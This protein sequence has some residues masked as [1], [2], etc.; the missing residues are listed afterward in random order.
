MKNILIAALMAPL[1]LCAGCED[2]N[3]G[4]GSG[5]TFPGQIP[6][7]EKIPVVAW[8]G[9][10]SSF[11][12][13]E[14]FK[15]AEAMG[16]TLNYSRM[17]NTT[18]AMKMLDYAAQTNIKLIVE[19]DELYKD[20]ER[21]AAVRRLMNHKALA[22]Y[23]ID[24]EPEPSKFEGIATRIK[25][26]SAIDP[27]H[28]C[29][30]N[31]FPT[32][33]NETY[34]TAWGKP[35]G[36]GYADYAQE[37]IST[38]K[39]QFFSFDEYPIHENGTGQ[40]LMKGTWFPTLEIARDEADKNN[41]ELWAFLLT[42]P[43]TAYPQPTHDHLRMQAYSNLAYGAQVLQCFT[44][45][46]PTVDNSV[47]NWNYRNGPIEED[48]TRSATYNVV[49]NLLEEVQTLAWIFRGCEV[50]RV[51]HLTPEV[52]GPEKTTPLLP[53]NMPEMAEQITIPKGESIL[54]SVIKNH[55]YTFM[56]VVNTNINANANATIKMKEGVRIVDHTGKITLASAADPVQVIT[57]GDIR[58]Y[59]W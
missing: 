57:P 21:E 14:R 9:V 59:M 6:A 37:F 52:R 55:G 17:Q 58:I 19:I 56:A 32:L 18:T 3:N 1:L 10:R 12:S 36:Y 13:V 26:I 35:A 29:Y 33:P 48:G 22:G 16:I 28:I 5:K 27:H 23:F 15:E 38:C 24:D 43:H 40:I 44:Y 49:K 41:L 47:I 45:W 7:A 51:M 31:I 42:V 34:Q 11:A 25:E 53:K 39:P 4:D 2:D 50:D 8:H 46:T 54:V 30:C 20:S